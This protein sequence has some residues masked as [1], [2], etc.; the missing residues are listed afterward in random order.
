MTLEENDAPSSLSVSSVTIS[1]V[2]MAAL[3][4]GRTTMAEDDS[5]NDVLEV[6]LN[7][8]SSQLWSD[9]IQ[10]KEESLKCLTNTGFLKNSPSIV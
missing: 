6:T 9:L 3:I 10:Q 8:T 2:K 5:F 4:W 7:T 1:H